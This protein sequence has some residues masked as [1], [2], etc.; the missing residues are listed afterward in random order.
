MNKKKTRHIGIKIKRELINSLITLFILFFPWTIKVTGQN[1]M[2]LTAG[3]GF[4]GFMNLGARA[5][6]K[7]SQIG[8]TVGSFPFSKSTF[9]TFSGDYYYHFGDQLFFTRRK[10]TYA[11]VSLNYFKDENTWEKNIMA[12]AGISAGRDIYISHKSGI[13]LD[14]GLFIMLKDLKKNRAPLD[15]PDSL[16][17]PTL[18]SL[19]PYVSVTFFYRL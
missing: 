7:Q 19:M 16:E 14:G 6:L 11:K 17:L 8:F 12:S 2:D 9:L 5:Q 3:I 13:N 18:P 10:S 1:T 15:S 4:P